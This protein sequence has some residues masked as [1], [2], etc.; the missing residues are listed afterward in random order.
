MGELLDERLLRHHA[1]AD[2][3]DTHRAVDPGG[4]VHEVVERLGHLG[5]EFPESTS[6]VS[7]VHPRS[8]ARRTLRGENR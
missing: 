2:L 5:G 1:G 3:V 8:R 6:R 7:A 4:V